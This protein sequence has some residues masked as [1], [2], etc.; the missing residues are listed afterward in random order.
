MRVGEL[1]M[2]ERIVNG[3]KNWIRNHYYSLAFL[4]LVGSIAHA[5]F[6]GGKG[7][8]T[9]AHI[10]TIIFAIC[11]IL[12]AIGEIK[13]VWKIIALMFILI[14][15]TILGF[16][17][18]PFVLG[19]LIGGGLVILV[20]NIKA[21]AVITLILIIFSLFGFLMVSLAEKRTGMSG[22]IYS[23]DYLLSEMAAGHFTT[24]FGGIIGMAIM[25]IIILFSLYFIVS[26]GA[27]R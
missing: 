24:L 1:K 9:A 4:G 3:A 19:V 14:I 16:W 10:A 27:K 8:E 18:L 22:D 20:K 15:A 25:G 7:G 17:I 12:I 13:G 26:S 21:I 23:T 2:F 5:I 6:V 11:W